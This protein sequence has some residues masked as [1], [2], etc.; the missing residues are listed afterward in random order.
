MEMIKNEVR[1]NSGS[2]PNCF[3]QGNSGG[4]VKVFFFH[5]EHNKISGLKS[6]HILIKYANA[7]DRVMQRGEDVGG[8]IAKIKVNV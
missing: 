5:H 2:N 1:S 7:H 8:N 3:F 4:H 6:F